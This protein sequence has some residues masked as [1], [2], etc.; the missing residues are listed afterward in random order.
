MGTTNIRGRVESRVRLG[1]GE[2]IFVQVLRD[3]DFQFAI[4]RYTA[5]T[6]Q[7]LPEHLER[8]HVQKSGTSTCCQ[9]LLAIYNLFHTTPTDEIAQ[10]R[11]TRPRLLQFSNFKP[12]KTLVCVHKGGYD[13]EAIPPVERQARNGLTTNEGEITHNNTHLAAPCDYL[14]PFPH[15]PFLYPRE[16]PHRTLGSRSPRPCDAGPLLRA[17]SPLR[18]LPSPR[19]ILGVLYHFGMPHQHPTELLPIRGG[20]GHLSVA[21]PTLPPPPTGGVTSS[22]TCH[23]SRVSYP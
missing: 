3:R 22:E 9:N 23:T 16:F 1:T 17:L 12:P 7:T 18:I 2:A 5:L 14:P 21:A 8:V 4:S 10:V 11:R 15:P 6:V 19:S 13:K 20:K